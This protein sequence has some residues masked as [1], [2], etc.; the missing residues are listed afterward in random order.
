V[1]SPQRGLPFRER[2]RNLD[3]CLHIAGKVTFNPDYIH[4]SLWFTCNGVVV[5]SIRKQMFN[6][7][8][9]LHN[10][11]TA[12]TVGKISLYIIHAQQS[13]MVGRK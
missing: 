12:S 11:K 6:I 8:I 1:E 10:G 4:T 2:S 9:P 3:Q 13:S 5:K 7:H